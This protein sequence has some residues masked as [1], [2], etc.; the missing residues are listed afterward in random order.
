ML[1]VL[2]TLQATL[3]ERVEA[4][5]LGT[6]LDRFTQRFE[7]ARVVG[8]RVL[9]NHEN[10]IGQFQVVKHHGAF[11]HPQ[12][13]RHARAAGFVAHVGA[14][15]EIVGA[16]G[17]HEQLVEKR[18]FIAGPARGVELG[19]VR[20]LQCAQVPGNQLER[21][22]P[23]GFHVMVGGCVI[24]HRVRQA[25]LVLKPVVGLLLQRAD[26]VLGKEGRVHRAAGGFPVDR[27]G[28]VF[29]ELDHVAFR[30]L[31]PGTARAVEAAVL[32]G[33]EHGPQVL[34]GVVTAQPALGHA[35]Q[36]PPAGGGAF[37]VPDVFVLAHA[38]NP[39]ASVLCFSLWSVGRGVQSKDL[40]A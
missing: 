13:F 3:F 33:L 17:T 21:F 12:G 1:R 40:T 18:R 15:R 34:E 22:C 2:E 32:V 19:F 24:A 14:V 38:V 9:A 31:A 5:H 37:V 4:H 20:R 25:A 35:F 8:A 28:A 36:R 23:G 6:A 11:A 27:L 7:H 16:I 30:R 10:G 39:H 29:T 26:A